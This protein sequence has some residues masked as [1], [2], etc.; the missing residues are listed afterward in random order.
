[1]SS[2]LSCGTVSIGHNVYPVFIII[3][4]DGVYVCYAAAPDRL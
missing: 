2:C 3:N 4:H 1:M